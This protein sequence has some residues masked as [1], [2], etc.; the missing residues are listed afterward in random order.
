MPLVKCRLPG[1]CR[2]PWKALRLPCSV[3]PPSAAAETIPPQRSGAKPAGLATVTARL[4]CPVPTAKTARRIAGLL[5][6]QPVRSGAVGLFSSGGNSR[7]QVLVYPVTGHRC[8]LVLRS[9]R[10]TGLSN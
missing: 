6:T 4:C 7:R 2:Q 8:R 10:Q 1:S 9:V 3:L 5:D